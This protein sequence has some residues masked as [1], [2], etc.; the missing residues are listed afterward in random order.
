M[1]SDH[2]MIYIEKKKDYVLILVILGYGIQSEKQQVDL[3]F[4]CH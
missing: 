3:Y 2:D 4:N 1:E